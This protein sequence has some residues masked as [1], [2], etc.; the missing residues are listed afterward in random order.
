MDIARYSLTKPI[1]IW[2]ISL[3]FILGSFIA[4]QNI[5]RLEDPAFTIKKAIIVTSYPGASAET[6]EK[7]VTEQIEIAL[8]QM[9]QIDYLTSE[10]QPGLSRIS[11]NILPTIDGPFLPQIWDEL[12]K[13][14]RDLR[15]DL[16]KGVSPPLVIDDFGDVYGMYYAL[17]APDFTAQQLREFARIFRRELL[18]VDGV[19]KVKVEGVLKEEIV[20]AVDMYQVAGLGISFPDIEQVLAN[21]LTSFSAGRVYAG[22]KKIRI[23]VE[24]AFNKTEEIANLAIVLPGRKATIKLKD[25]ADISIQAVEIPKSLKR[26]NGQPTITIAVSAQNGINIVAIGEKITEKLNE[27]KQKLPAGITISPI[28]NQALVVEQAVD[29]FI[30][31]LELSV[32]V[33]TIALCLFMGWRSGIVVGG[34]LLVTI[35]GTIVIMWLYGLQLQRISL[36]AMVIAMG[37]LVDNA[38]VVAEG[39]MM[40]M[41]QGKTAL[42]AASYIVKRTQWPLLGATIIGIAAFSGIGLSDDKTGEFLFSLFAVVFISLMLSWV[43][44]ITLTPLLSRYFYQ[45]TAQSTTE[46]YHSVIHKSY[47]VLLTK[48][49]RWRKLTLLLLVAITV[50]AYASFGFIKQGFFPNSNT[51]V[52]FIH[53][54]GAQHSDIRAT[55]KDMISAEKVILATAGVS[56]VTSFIGEGSERFTLVLQPQLPNESYGLFLVRVD[57]AEDIARLAKLIPEQLKQQHLNAQ[58][59]AQVMQYGP[60]SGAK[61]AVRFSGSDPKVLRDLARQAK[62]IYYQ[63]GRIR[64]IRDDWREK[65]IVLLPEYD[66]IAAGI[67]GVSRRDFSETIAL[68]SQGLVIGQLQD[69]DYRYPIIARN[70]HQGSNQIAEL[71]NSL[72]WS[73]SQRTYIPFKQISSKTQYLTE[74]LLINRRDRLRTITVKAE[75]GYNETAAEAFNRTRQAIESITLP[76]GYQLAWGGEFESSKEAQSAL[77][78]GLPLGFLVMFIVSVLL[79][80]R[81]RQPII[82]WSVVPMAI[83]GVVAGLLIADLPFGFMSLLGFL[84]LFGML[85]KNAIVLLEEI[86]L[87]IAEGKAAINAVTEASLSRLRPVALAAITT[88]LG[89][90]PLV[91][92]A[93]FADMAVTIIGGLAFATI[94]TMIAVPVLYCLLY[95]VKT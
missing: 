39:I 8:Q 22:G 76:D 30:L 34:T 58:F 46:Q 7:E 94:L 83:V 21:K 9:W 86:D 89:V 45:V 10:N 28:Y 6:V 72:V 53:Y 60:G 29:G 56:S 95:K 55:E 77:A 64:D 37:M 80:G 51:P 82:I 33:V 75:A 67:A 32:A 35:L 90:V 79:F 62:N 43:L 18:A 69:G 38:I 12:R 93:F 59:Y 63:D 16:P 66:E 52:F 61:L 24:K 5:G 42:Q 81:A 4:M 41:Q 14:M 47:L 68:Y 25:I 57:D 17:S 44:A 13:R 87:Q 50:A 70:K 20:V 74:E 78:S 3:C 26:H 23:P 27:V 71:N 2:L 15:K 85:I 19:A 11:V 31:N 73:S 88:I 1:S 40:R 84:S 48:A 54:W 36:G 49:L 91:N 92:D 65:G